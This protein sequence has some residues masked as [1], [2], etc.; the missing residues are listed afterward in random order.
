MPTRAGLLD[1]GAVGRRIHWSLRSYASGR[2]LLHGAAVDTQ[3]FACLWP[4]GPGT[5]ADLERRAGRYAIVAAALD[6]TDMQGTCSGCSPLNSMH[7][8]SNS[9]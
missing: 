5:G 3:D 6:H 7:S 1:G 4:L 8:M 9:S 2:L